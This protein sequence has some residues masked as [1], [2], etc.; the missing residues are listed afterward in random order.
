MKGTVA[1][2][3]ALGFAGAASGAEKAPAKADAAAG[4]AI[5]TKVCAACHGADGN[6]PAPANPKLAGQVPEYIAHQLA[7]FKANKERKN[8]VMFGMAST[9]SPQ[10]MQNVAA[11]FGAQKAK[12]GAVRKKETVDLGRKIY[13]GGDNAKGVPACASC[14]GATGAGLPAQ[15]PRLAGQYADYTEAQLKAFRSGERAN[16][17]AKMMR[18]IAAK[19]SDAD[20]AAVADYIAGLH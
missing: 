4:Q 1:L 20:I 8:P 15:Y 10:D 11:Y 19:M 14:H 17:P 3:V 6:S 12:D 16:D 7:D 5:V 2:L 13:R 18:T 9:L